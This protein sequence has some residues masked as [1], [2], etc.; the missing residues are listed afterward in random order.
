M[1][2][3]AGRKAPVVDDGP[4]RARPWV[5]ERTSWVALGAGFLVLLLVVPFPGSG[6][7]SVAA[8]PAP[9]TRPAPLTF[10]AANVGPAQPG[11][12]NASIDANVSD[13]SMS[14]DPLTQ[15]VVAVAENLTANGTFSDRMSTWS[16]GSNG[17]TELHPTTSP[18]ARIGASL[19]YDP[20]LDSLVLFG[21]MGPSGYLSDTWMYNGSAW[22]NITASVGIAPPGR[23]SAS[24]VWDPVSRVV[25][26]Y[27]GVGPNGTSW[28]NLSTDQTS[29]WLLGPGGWSSVAQASASVPAPFGA[30]AFDTADGYLVDFGGTVGGSGCSASAST[31]EFSSGQWSN[32]SSMVTGAPPARWNAAA[33]YD[34]STSSVIVFGGQDCLSYRNDTWSYS[35][36]QWSPVASSGSPS[37]RSIP[38]LTDDARAGLLVLFGGIA[39]NGPQADTWELSS[40]GWTLAGPLLSVSGG[41]ETGGFV[42][43]D[44]GTLLN[45]S[46][47]ATFAIGGVVTAFTG[48]PS[49]C[50][51]A[52]AMRVLCAAKVPGMYEVGATVRSS[53]GEVTLAPVTISILAPP[54]I[55]SVLLSSTATEAGVPVTIRAVVLNGSGAYQ[56]VYQD[57]PPGCGT[58]D[59]A[60]LT[61]D[62]TDTG[63]F[64]VLVT[65]IDSLGASTTVEVPLYVGPHPYVDRVSASRAI[66]DAGLPLEVSIVAGGGVGPL[67]F[68]YSDLP[69]GCTSSNTSGLTC[70]PAANGTFTV[71][72]GVIDPFGFEASSTT[73]F[74]V[75]PALSAPSF[76][77]N[78]TNVTLDTSVSLTLTVRD[79]TAPYSYAYSG[80]PSG[81]AP[82]NASVLVCAP[83]STGRY[84]IRAVA[85]DALG[86]TVAANVTI[87]VALARSPG[88]G[89]PPT[90]SP[91]TDSFPYG[92]A[93]GL[94]LAVVAAAAL[95]VG[96][97]VRRQRRF[98]R[99][100]REIVARMIDEAPGLG[101][102]FGRFDDPIDRR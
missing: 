13:V 5:R 19:V 90:G 6:G 56:Y 51:P 48:L 62:P 63:A 99:E 40:T 39:L 7:V 82:T 102:E 93:L 35:G 83:R 65:A 29:T 100:G 96:L 11:R 22:S 74:T 27:G 44:A 89:N 21:G 98:A 95:S 79:G 72:G 76:V 37:Q 58:E 4:L 53:T 61:C 46:V 33:T 15:S 101:A 26:L 41:S 94:A 49:A 71:R 18:T 84:T 31:W 28:S 67:T 80:L 34:V 3:S 88:P 69:S 60:V 36:G 55:V 42:V 54:A 12:V 24:F 17:W 9:P 57:L 92:V 77:A 43:A 1:A 78:A 68:Q 23:A 2:P 50:S 47:Q 85:T 75:H 20:P 25:V 59:V 52:T 32:I 30:M 64:N 73:T 97:L 14:Y 81:C 86:E 70:V 38:K 66:S 87:T 10:S 91:G 8:H 45:I 16:F